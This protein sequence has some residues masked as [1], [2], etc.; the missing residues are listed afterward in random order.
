MLKFRL[1]ELMDKKGRR[2][3]RRVL[4]NDVSE[5]TGIHRMTLS[6]L[7]NREGY[8]VSSEI[9]DR[10]CAYFECPIEQLVQYVPDEIVSRR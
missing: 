2:E 10:L 1:R 9:L 7:L 3:K 5:A 4:V 8:N 6:R